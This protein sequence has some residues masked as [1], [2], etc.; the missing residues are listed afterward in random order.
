LSLSDVRLCEVGAAYGWFLEAVEEHGIARELIA[1]EPSMSLANTCEK[2]GFHTIT[3]PLELAELSHLVD[4]VAAFEVIEHVFSPY[5]FL[6]KCLDLLNPGGFLF[7]S[8]PSVRGFDVQILGKASGVFQHEH[9]NYFHPES[10]KVLLE[11]IGFQGVEV[12]T[13]GL[14]DVD[15]VRSGLKE[16]LLNP[17]EIPWLGNFILRSDPNERQALQEFVQNTKES[18]H[19]FVMA[20]KPAT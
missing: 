6:A 16:G 17:S 7:L 3:S 12:S 10:V 2:K 13:P 4:V 1:I 18:S 5:D 11:R 9:L 14:L 15:I 8:C 20:R 19:M